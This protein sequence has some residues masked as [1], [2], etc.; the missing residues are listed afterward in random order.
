MRILVPRSSGSPAIRRV[1]SSPSM[2]GIRMS[3][4]TTSGRVD[5]AR[6]K[7]SAP[8]SASP[9]TV[10]SSALARIALNPLRTSAWSSAT[11]DRDHRSTPY[12]SVARTR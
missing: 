4:S 7:A 3:M 10:M 12:G 2:T 1:A 5:A 9:V 11:S 6:A 8:F